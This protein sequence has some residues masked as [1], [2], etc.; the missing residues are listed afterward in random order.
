VG[1]S[2]PLVNGVTGLALLNW[3]ERDG[4]RQWLEYV[5]SICR[6]LST[7]PIEVE[8][9]AYYP[10]ESS[11]KPDGTW[12]FSTRWGSQ[13]YY[14]YEPPEEPEFDQQCMEGS[15]K[16][17]Q[18]Q[19]YR[20][21]AKHYAST[22]N[23]QS[24]EAARKIARFVLKPGLWEDTTSEGY[25]G[26]EHGIWA[27]HFHAN[28][29]NLHALLDLAVIERDEWLKQ[30]VREGYDQAVRSGVVRM[31]WFPGWTKPEK[32]K[33]PAYSHTI[34]ESCGLAD[35]VILAVELSDAGIGD[36]WDDVDSIVRNQLS[37]QQ[38]IDLGSMRHLVGG[39]TSHDDTLKRAIGGF[40]GAAPTCNEP[41][42]WGCCSANGA[43]GLY[44]AWHGITRFDNGVATVNLFLNRAAPWMDIDS[45]LP[46][47]GKVVLHNKKAHTVLVRIPAWV[48]MEEVKASV[49]GE[50]VQPPKPGRYLVFG[51]LKDDADIVLEFPLLEQT[52]HYFVHDTQYTVTFRGSTVIDISPRNS[53]PGKVPLYR[54]EHFKARKTPMHRVKR[55]VADKVL[56]LQ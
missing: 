48:K 13:R 27:G 41:S 46:Y 36:Y 3:Y 52:D 45:Y 56:P 42:V 35:M 31:G 26:H 43:I 38:F 55:F 21:L 25:P 7:I 39:D 10:P 18:S 8:D 34:T 29:T 12:H 16:F 17:E 11:Y 9:R 47:Q 24:I 5:Q 40:S 1:T 37:E 14:P 28:I 19:A 49:D 22:G 2:Y 32:F 33:R 15:V 53:E 44:Y 23:K 54:R 6:G 20:L 50:A 51:D 4:N 30:F